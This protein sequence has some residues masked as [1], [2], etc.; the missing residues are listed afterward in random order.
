MKTL[1]DYFPLKISGC[2]ILKQV[3]SDNNG[4]KHKRM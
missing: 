1:S 4:Q 2:S 3:V